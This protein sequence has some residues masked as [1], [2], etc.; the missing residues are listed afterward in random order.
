MTDG[1]QSLTPK[2]FG[3]MMKSIKRAAAVVDREV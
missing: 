3:E 1:V 2:Q